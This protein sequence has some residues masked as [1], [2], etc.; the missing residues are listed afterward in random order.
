M[1]SL[2]FLKLVVKI[3]MSDITDSK[4]ARKIAAR[5]LTSDS[6]FEGKT[7]GNGS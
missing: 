7:I 2:E 4:T 5:I 3:K 6:Y 1:V